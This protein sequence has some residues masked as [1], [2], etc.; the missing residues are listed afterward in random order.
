MDRYIKINSADTVAVAVHPL[1][2]GETVE[3]DGLR[4]TLAEDIPAGHKFA[5]MDLHAGDN[6]IKYGFPIGPLTADA[7]AGNR[8][9]HSKRRTTLEG[10]LD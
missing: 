8:S 4:L 7:H 5:L 3:I 9:D 6:V 1:S 2:S 10:L